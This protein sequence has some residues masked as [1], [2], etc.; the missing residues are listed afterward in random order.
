MG[1][2]FNKPAAPVKRTNGNARPLPLPFPDLQQCGRLRVGHLL[3]VFG[4]SSPEFYKRLKAGQIP[5]PAG[6]D[7]RPYWEA[8]T[9]RA[10]LARAVDEAGL[11]L[12]VEGV[13]KAGGA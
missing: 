11:P 6:K 12:L 13:P 10:Y 5:A 9:V 2:S 1:I 7:P 4:I 3:T 8:Q